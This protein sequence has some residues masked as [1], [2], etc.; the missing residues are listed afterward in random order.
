MLLGGTPKKP[1]RKEKHEG[2]AAAADE[3]PEVFRDPYAGLPQGVSS[4]WLQAAGNSRSESIAQLEAM[5]GCWRG[6][7]RC[8]V[9][10]CSLLYH[11]VGASC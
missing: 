4:A 7:T 6:A 5:V 10:F 11:V 1:R 9:L 2:A 8:F 3:Q